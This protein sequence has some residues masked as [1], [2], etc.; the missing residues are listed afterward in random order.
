MK[1]VGKCLCGAI[2][3]TGALK[4][5]CAHACHCGLCRRQLG[6][7]SLTTALQGPPEYTRGQDR[8]TTYPSTQWGERCFCSVCGTNLFHNAPGFGY[9]GVSAGV[10]DD[11]TRAALTMDKEIYVDS[12]PQY[13]NLEGDHPRLTEAEFLASLGM[14]GGGGGE[15]DTSIE[16][17]ETTKP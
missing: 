1:F 16:E 3:F 10:L 13:Y 8:V 2:Q 9:Y 17:E 5:P 4:E 11:E 6:A 14:G 12:K 15:D 7:P